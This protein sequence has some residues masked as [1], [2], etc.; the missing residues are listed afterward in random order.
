MAAQ[1]QDRKRSDEAQIL[2]INSS[3]KK[4]ADQVNADI[5]KAQAAATP[6]GIDKA[7]M[8]LDSAVGDVKDRQLKIIEVCH[9]C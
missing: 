7:A 3:L 6:S 9:Y 1:L 8:I 2:A 5:K 4:W